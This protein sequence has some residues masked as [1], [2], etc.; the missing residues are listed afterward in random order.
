MD[1]LQ[2]K[3]QNCTCINGQILARERIETFRIYRTLCSL[4]AESIIVP[5]FLAFLCTMITYHLRTALKRYYWYY[6]DSIQN[7]AQHL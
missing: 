3:Q 2:A 5:A 7:W 6:G 4:V 1:F